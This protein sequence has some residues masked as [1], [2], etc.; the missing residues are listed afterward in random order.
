MGAV[1]AHCLSHK[2][3]FGPPCQ[4]VHVRLLSARSLVLSAHLLLLHLSES[5]AALFISLPSSLA[6]SVFSCPVTLLNSSLSLSLPVPPYWSRDAQLFMAVGMSLEASNVI[7]PHH[8]PYEVPSLSKRLAT[9]S[10]LCLTPSRDVPSFV[11][12]CDSAIHKSLS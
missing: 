7:V 1:D 9:T 11:R 2:I 12:A 5:I 6:S 3:E 10:R 8:T 4:E